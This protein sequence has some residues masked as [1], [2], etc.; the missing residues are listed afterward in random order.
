MGSG[1]VH[2]PMSAATIGRYR[3]LKKIAAGGMAEIYLARVTG[4]GGFA[5]DVV[6]KRILPQLAES[7][8]FFRM[9]LDE[10]R[11]AATLQHPNVVQVYD[12]GEADGQYYIAME[13][14]TGGDLATLRRHLGD[15]DQRLALQHLVYVVSCVCAGLHYAHEKLDLDGRPLGIVHRDVTPQ[16]IFV[17][18][19][20]GVKLVDFGIA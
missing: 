8:Q 2:E 3:L 7:E 9:F 6:L 14:L 17:T 4:V 1:D 12:A 20:G 18:R 10:A 15:R 19:D 5:K 16:N 13:H 11:I